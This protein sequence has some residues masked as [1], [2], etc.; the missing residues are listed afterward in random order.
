VYLILH[1][2][3]ADFPPKCGV[4]TG[5][6]VATSK[7][8]SS[9]DILEHCLQILLHFPD[10]VA[11]ELALVWSLSIG[12]TTNTVKHQEGLGCVPSYSNKQFCFNR[13]F[14]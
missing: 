2:C 14:N 8:K 6:Q 7:E 10:Y 5:L 9:H 4:P 11:V 13:L 1:C 12:D 3:L